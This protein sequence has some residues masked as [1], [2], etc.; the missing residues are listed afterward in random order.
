MKKIFISIAVI[1]AIIIGG[2]I[3]MA[4]PEAQPEVNN[5]STRNS[6]TANEV[7]MQGLEFKPKKLTVKKGS[8]VNWKNLDD[9]KHN[10]VFDSG[11]KSG[12]EGELFGKGQ[13]YSM[14]FDQTGTYEY[15]CRPHPYMKGVIEV[16][17]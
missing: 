12:T 14:T 7:I 16:V 17:E 4:G 6:D 5:G 1:G 8:T 13:S 9:A 11:P 3:V 2:I 10:I 15:H